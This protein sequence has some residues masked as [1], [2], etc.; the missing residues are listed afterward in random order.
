VKEKNAEN[1]INAFNYLDMD[2]AFTPDDVLEVD[3][4]SI[5]KMVDE[6]YKY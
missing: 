1:L 2:S 3:S 4:N 6:L 5:R